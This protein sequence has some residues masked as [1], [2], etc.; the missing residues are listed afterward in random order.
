MKTTAR[1]ASLRVDEN[2]QLTVLIGS[3]ARGT[4]DRNS[5]IDIVRVGHRNRF[6]KSKVQCLKNAK[7]PISYVDYEPEAFASLYDSGSL[8]IHHVLNEGSLVQGDELYWAELCHSFSVS[9]DFSAEIREYLSLCHWLARP[10]MFSC[11]V[12]PLLSHMFR[13]LKNAAIF[14]LA[15]RGLYIYDRRC[16]ISSGRFLVA[17]WTIA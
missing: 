14:L 4:P 5:D 3:F 9:V 7:A 6:A 10:R 1:F 2:R 11:A 16:P 13:G 15:Q 8:F 12:M 17:G